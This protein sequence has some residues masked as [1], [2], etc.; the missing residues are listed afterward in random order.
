MRMDQGGI[1]KWLGS[2]VVNNGPLKFVVANSRLLR[3]QLCARCSKSERAIVGKRL[4]QGTRI[5][6]MQ[7]ATR[8]E[9]AK[10]S[11]GV[12]VKDERGER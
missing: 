12:N 2:N 8:V 11:S 6:R 5:K 3:G 10:V 1:K 4:L 9:N 7:K